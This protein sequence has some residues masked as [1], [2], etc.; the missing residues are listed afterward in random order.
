MCMY[1]D[2]IEKRHIKTDYLFF[3]DSDY[4]YILE[5]YFCQ[6]RIDLKGMWKFIVMTKE[7]NKSI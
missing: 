7:I 3:S 4:E 6:E 2:T 1:Q 5:Y